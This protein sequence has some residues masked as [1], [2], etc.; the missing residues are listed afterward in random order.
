MRG[1]AEVTTALPRPGPVLTVALALVGGLGILFA[2]L[3]GYAP[4]A[5]APFGYLVFNDQ[6]VLRGQVWRLVTSG[7]LTS[8]VS[9]EHL[10]YSLVGLYFLSPTLERR[11]GG[12]RFA[13]FL[14]L[15]VTAGNLTSLAMNALLAGHELRPELHRGLL[16]GPAAALAAT[17]VA[18]AREFP[19][20]QVRLFFFLPVAG[21][22]FL[23]ITLGF[24]VLG[25]I[26]P[27]AAPEGPWAPFGGIL[28]GLLLAGSPS[29][30]RTLVL[31]GRLAMLRRKSGHLRSV[32]DLADLGDGPPSSSRRPRSGAPPLRAVPG[33]LDDALKKHKPPKD[34]RHLN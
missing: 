27:G 16:L 11:W 10:L 9:L 28:T 26:Y 1:S 17:A 8:P 3:Y 32:R 15:A 34:K 22:A 33:G 23:W 18:W 12:A 14:L 25:L 13:R 7:A 6:L 2:I 20:E 5:T 4:G 24:A 19:R 31:K 21:R 30:L 29:A